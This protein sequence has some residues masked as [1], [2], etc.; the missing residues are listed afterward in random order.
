MLLEVGSEKWRDTILRKQ[1]YF[2]PDTG[3]LVVRALVGVA[4]TSGVV[5]SI[6][7]WLKPSPRSYLSFVRDVWKVRVEG[8]AS[9]PRWLPHMFGALSCSYFFGQS[10]QAIL[11]YPLLVDVLGA[12]VLQV[13]IIDASSQFFAAAAD[14]LLR[15][16]PWKYMSRSQHFLVH[17]ALTAFSYI[18]IIGFLIPSF[19]SRRGNF[20]VLALVLLSQVLSG[21]HLMFTEYGV[22]RNDA[23]E[24]IQHDPT[25]LIWT[26]PNKISTKLGQLQVVLRYPATLMASAVFSRFL[27]FPG[28]LYW[29][30][31][32]VGVLTSLHGL[33][34]SYCW[35]GH[36]NSVVRQPPYLSPSPPALVRSSIL[37]Q[38]LRPGGRYFSKFLQ[39]GI[40]NGMAQ[41]VRNG[42]TRMIN[43]TALTRNL[44]PQDIGT[45]VIIVFGVSVCFFWLSDNAAHHDE[46]RTAGLLGFFLLGAGHVSMGMAPG[47]KGLMVSSL[48]FGFGQAVSTGLRTVR[49]DEVRIMM[50]QDGHDEAYRKSMIRI[51]AGFGTL[52]AIVNSLAVGFIGDTFGMDFA[53]YFY[54]GVAALGFLWTYLEV[55][56]G[57]HPDDD[58][59][60]SLVPCEP[61]V[62]FDS[63]GRK[64][65]SHVTAEVE[66]ETSH[67][68]GSGWQR[69]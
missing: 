63:R 33:Y 34:L 55:S 20:W 37:W 53:S 67:E 10:V 11:H 9:K 14:V 38:D 15:T 29:A 48:L 8:D 50:R 28:G 24:D 68:T 56:S 64:R 18:G 21:L 44:P 35:R 39:V 57:D 32:V 3:E 2:T 1:I 59:A 30:Y 31:I 49:K 22:M 51:L 19:P 62:P 58:L 47:F 5:F 54:G 52:T 61:K 12:N 26:D 7:R 65:D 43:L 42:Y 6:V 36:E 41:V 17:S 40:F 60:E 46:R 69:A 16:G 45:L 66:R 4:I 13:G 27:S 23:K 25:V